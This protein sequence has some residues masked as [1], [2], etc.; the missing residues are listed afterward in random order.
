[1]IQKRVLKAWRQFPDELKKEK[2][3]EKRRIE[4]MKKVQMFIPD[5]EGAVDESVDIS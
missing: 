1:M 5:Y 3:R 2:E 4:M